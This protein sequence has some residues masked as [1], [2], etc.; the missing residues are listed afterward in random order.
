[1]GYPMILR[2]IVCTGDIPD[3]R[4]D[5][6]ASTCSTKCERSLNQEKTARRSRKMRGVTC[7]TC[8]RYIGRNGTETALAEG[9]RLLRG[10]VDKNAVRFV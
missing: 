2:C 7:P 10:A 6:N 4:L 5:R 8:K 3:K 9:V 1:M